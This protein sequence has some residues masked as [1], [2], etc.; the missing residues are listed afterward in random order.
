MYDFTNIA[1][2]DNPTPKILREALREYASGGWGIKAFEVIGIINRVIL[3]EE[4]KRLM[5]E[6]ARVGAFKRNSVCGGSGAG[7]YEKVIS[8]LK[9]EK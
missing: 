8:Y 1:K 7:E 3:T 9:G 6:Y 4:D 5:C 2:S